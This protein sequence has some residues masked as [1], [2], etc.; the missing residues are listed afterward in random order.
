MEEAPEKSA[1]DVDGFLTR[2]LTAGAET[3]VET[4]PVHHDGK[5]EVVPISP[6]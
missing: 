1:A 5:V 2:A 6:E 3:P 4:A